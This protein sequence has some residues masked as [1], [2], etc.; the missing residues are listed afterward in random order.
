MN[1]AADLFPLGW[2]VVA[3]LGGLGVGLW[4]VRT[5]PWKR[6]LDGHQLNAVLGATVILALLWSINAGVRPGLNLHLVG[7]MA[8]TLIF[9]PQLALLVLALT[10]GAIT[11]NGSIAWSAYPINLLLMVIIP[12]ALATLA[13]RLVERV[14][15]KHFFIYI[16]VNAFL[17]AALVVLAQGTERP[18][19]G[20]LLDNKKPGVYVCRL[21][22][23]PLFKAGQDFDAYR[24][25]GRLVFQ[26]LDTGRERQIIVSTSGRA[27]ICDPSRETCTADRKSVV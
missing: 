9:G 15:P 16:F 2:H 7:G 14:L 22:G 17:C 21:C 11:L 1:L 13:F 10:L 20:T 6:L 27:R 3:I 5:G 25:N 26:T 4:V 24:Q 12:V 23:L 8:V 18:F 19:C